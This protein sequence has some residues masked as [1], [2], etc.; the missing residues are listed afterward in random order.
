M[1]L[2]NVAVRYRGRRGGRGG[3][4]ALADI[5]LRIGA[6][7]KLGVVGGNGAGKSTLLR[8]M[9]GALAPDAG[10]SDA[11]GAS[12]ALLSLNAGFDVELSGARN[13]VMHGML[14]GL[15]R[16]QALTRVPHVVQT[17][18][19]GDA[20]HR[21]VATYSD[22]MRA[23]LGFWTAMNLD[24]DI[25]LVD[26]VLSVGDSEF[27]ERSRQA[28]IDRLRSERTVVL[29]SHNVDFLERMCERVIWLE[30]GRVA[31]DGAAEEVLGSYRSAGGA[32]SADASRN[33]R[34]A[35]KVLAPKREAR[36]VRERDAQLASKQKA[37]PAPEQ[38][39]Q[40][41]PEQEVRPVPKQLFVCG[42][43]GGVAQS[44]ATVLNAHPAIVLGLARY[45]RLLAGQPRQAHCEDWPA[46]FRSE[47]FLTP[48]PEDTDAP[49]PL[50]ATADAL[51]GKIDGAAYVG[52]A[53]GGLD[54]R[55][56]FLRDA[57]P[58]CAIVLVVREPVSATAAWLRGEAVDAQANVGDIAPFV[59]Q[60]NES[61]VIALQA[62]RRLGRQL[63]CVSYDRLFGN[64]RR[65]TYRDLLSILG[66]PPAP[67]AASE[68][69]LE[70]MARELKRD[71]DVPARLRSMVERRADF[72]RYARL[73]HQVA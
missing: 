61:L 40:P 31:M 65:R 63:V 10:V 27:R 13:I 29:A 55:L 53:I 15:T 20:I 71:R 2:A 46:L 4:H 18:G 3:V 70:N 5:S 21:R 51:A 36:Q 1:R 73:L 32:V 24:P 64:G 47:R 8:V 11:E 50:P 60:W 12:T 69:L 26:E 22:G 54:E 19:L 25:L 43:P 16:R 49:H 6:R 28:M 23:R 48:R 42:A 68:A 30:R 9:A 58:N 45:G 41:A 14:T 57:F 62:R 44:V 37:Q 17:S 59:C 66:L 39:A 35:S 56:D 38:K 72:R 7:E 52:D 67:S 33:A 34:R